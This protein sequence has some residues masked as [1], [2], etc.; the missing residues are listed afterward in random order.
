[1]HNRFD[2][3]VKDVLREG[4]DRLGVTQRE[5]EVSADAQR[6]DFFFAP[7]STADPANEVAPGPAH[8]PPPIFARMAATSC[9]IE[10]YR[11][12]PNIDLV[13]GCLRKQLTWHHSRL[14]DAARDARQSPP[15]ELRAVPTGAPATPASAPPPTAP[16]EPPEI[17]ILWA[18]SGG[19]PADVMTG[20]AF[21]PLDGWPAGIYTGP[22]PAVP[23]RIVVLSELPEDRITLPLRLLGRGATLR[24]ALRELTALPPE[25]WESQHILP[26][27]V[28]LPIEVQEPD[29]TTVLTEDEKEMIVTAQEFIQDLRKNAE[30]ALQRGL[31]QGVQQGLQQGVQQGLQLVLHQFARKLG[32]PVSDD[33]RALLRARLDTLGPD[34]VGDVV[35]DLP[36]AALA[37]WLADP[38]AR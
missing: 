14:K 6:M 10:H 29:A 17:A 34:R 2:Q 19:R 22:L 21:Q 15:S 38:A 1:M 33:E 18:L 25:A 32:R 20:F 31:E 24:R 26:L 23:F 5:M 12:P 9:V 35:L 30:T 11:L 28:R 16:P 3:F 36:P 4:F 13:R 7:S 37:E 27:L 8:A